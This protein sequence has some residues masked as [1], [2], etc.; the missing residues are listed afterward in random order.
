MNI[1]IKYSS[2]TQLLPSGS[3]ERDT[4]ITKKEPCDVSSPEDLPSRFYLGTLEHSSFKSSEMGWVAR[5]QD[6]SP[7]TYVDFN[8]DKKNNTLFAYYFWEGINGMSTGSQG[9]DW[10]FLKRQ[11]G[12]FPKKWQEFA[13][14]KIESELNI[15]WVSELGN[16]PTFTGFPDGI[17]MTLTIP[18]PVFRLNEI[19]DVINTIDHDKN[20]AAKVTANVY[21]TNMRIELSQ[22][23]SS[24]LLKNSD[25]YLRYNH[26][27]VGLPC[28][29]LPL[30]ANDV[31][32]GGVNIINRWVPLVHVNCFFG[33]AFRVI[34]HFYKS[35]F[36][37]KPSKS[38]LS[39]S[40]PDGL[41]WT[42]ML[43]PTGMEFN[44]SKILISNTE[45]NCCVQYGQLLPNNHLDTRM[46]NIYI[47]NEQCRKLLNSTKTWA[48]RLPE[49]T[50]PGGLNL[51]V[52]LINGI[53]AG[54]VN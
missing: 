19:I 6:A 25:D 44:N 23:K 54:Y 40:Y 5:Y 35:G 37:A 9:E 17:F 47:S 41:E 7:D 48:S 52:D 22:N 12:H 3:T 1:Q 32:K 50:F 30:I 49:V 29:G 36:I 24:I 39:E 43:F 28:L 42:A 53:G 33:D 34:K 46:M 38:C 8:F 16:S 14:Q 10:K 4:S 13:K 20:V 11:I 31:D 26:N 2:S 18:V 21:I 27:E 45:Q 51:H 15:R